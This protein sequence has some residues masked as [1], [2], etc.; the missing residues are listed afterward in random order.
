MKV[1]E[2]KMSKAEEV[3]LERAESPLWNPS[4]WNKGMI[5]SFLD[6]LWDEYPGMY[7][8]VYDRNNHVGKD[9][10]MEIWREHRN[11]FNIARA[12]VADTWVNIA[13]EV[14]VHDRPGGIP[15]YLR[16]ERRMV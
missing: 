12:K 8:I 16:S 9:M 1:A 7:Q 2:E 6:A 10:I 4:L 3:Q 5:E 14:K 11:I 13:A 15:R